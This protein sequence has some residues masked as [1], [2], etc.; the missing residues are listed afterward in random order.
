MSNNPF[1]LANYKPQIS[2]RDREKAR[3]V[4]YQVSRHINE[5][6]KKGIE[7]SAPYAASVGGWPQ[8]YTTE[9]PEMPVHKQTIQARAR[10]M[11]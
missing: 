6:R 9:M 10:R 8:D 5:Q 4:A 1:D 2:M 7:P 11:T 3:K